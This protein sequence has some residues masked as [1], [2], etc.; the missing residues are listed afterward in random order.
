M[1]RIGIVFLLISSLFL[2]ACTTSTSPKTGNAAADRRTPGRVVDD[3]NIELLATRVLMNDAYVNDYSHTN[4]TVYNGVVLVT[5]EASSDEVRQ[6]IISMVKGVEGVKRVESDIVIG[7]TSSLLSRGTDSAITGKV[8]AS[9]LT[10]QVPGLSTTSLNVSTERGN[11][12]IMGMVTRQEANA[13]TEK[14]RR[15][16][17]VKSVI[18]VFEYID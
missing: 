11:V 3:K 8:V 9:L 4:L 2:G 1:T 13:I 6:K 16:G 7:P 15:V 5:G 17:G 18:K 10:L 14:A 12:Y